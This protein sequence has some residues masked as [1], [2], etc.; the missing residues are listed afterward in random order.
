MLLPH[1]PCSVCLPRGYPWLALLVPC[2]FPFFAVCL[3]VDDVAVVQV[4]QAQQHTS[5]HK[6]SAELVQRA[7]HQQHVQRTQPHCGQ[8]LHPWSTRTREGGLQCTLTMNEQWSAILSSCPNTGPSK[9][10]DIILFKRMGL[11]TSDTAWQSLKA[12]STRK[13][14]LQMCIQQMCMPTPLPHPPLTQP[15]SP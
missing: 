1:L 10:D 3:P 14:G 7:W 4:L 6:H 13:E 2:S 12:S 9:S 15:D 11:P 8:H 5:R